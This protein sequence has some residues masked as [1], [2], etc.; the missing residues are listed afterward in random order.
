MYISTAFLTGSIVTG[1]MLLKPPT[2]AFGAAFVFALS[3]CIVIG[4]LPHRKGVAIALEYLVD[5]RSQMESAS[6]QPPD[7]P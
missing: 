6:S 3:I 7:H 5:C 1:M 2:I 4:S